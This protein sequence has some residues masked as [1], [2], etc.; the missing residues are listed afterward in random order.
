MKFNILI[1]GDGS[2]P[3]TIKRAVP[4]TNGHV[5][6][7][8]A[9]SESNALQ[10][11][12]TRAAQTIVV[13]FDHPEFDAFQ[14]LQLVKRTV[15][16]SRDL[17]VVA[18]DPSVENTVRCMQLG[19]RD[20]VRLPDEIGRLKSCL[21]QLYKKWQ[22]KQN[23]AS[24]DAY[25]HDR[26]NPETIIGNCPQIHEIANIIQK[27][28]R[29]Q[30]VTVL[31]RG[32][33]GTGKGVIARVIHYFSNKGNESAPFVELN[34]TAIPE[35]L[36]ESE[37]FGYHKGAFTDARENKK[38]LLEVAEGGTLFLDEIGDMSLVLQAKLLKTIEE[39]RFRRLGGT[40]T[41]RVNTRIIAGTH[42][43]LERLIEE[44]KFRRDLFYRLN[45]VTIF[46]PPLRERGQDVLL[47]AEYFLEKYAAEYGAPVRHLSAEAQEVLLRHDWPGNVREL[48]H[49]LERIV[50]LGDDEI[51]GKDELVSALDTQ[52]MTTERS[53]RSFQKQRII[54]I[55]KEGLSLKEGEKKLI[56]E[57]LRMTKG[58]RSHAAQI[59]GISRPRLKRKI[60]EYRLN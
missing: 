46:L 51:I 17:I 28:S 54:E 37:L 30:W 20:V 24:I 27:I 29:R 6:I 42:A 14:F 60:D 49:T 58:N 57:V 8:V 5:S 41:M 50:L 26:F 1:L 31:L 59:L 7:S 53:T 36:L 47:L 35:T 9:T 22:D 18:K 34:C 52:R 55:P 12:T 3:S 44:G 45:V 2:L 19:A 13:D 21:E 23:A 33:T 16:D 11:I 25:T 39:K 32:E 48:Q 15:K 4:A 40:E 43:E 10:T 56:F 38:G